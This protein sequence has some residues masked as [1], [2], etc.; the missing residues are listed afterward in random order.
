MRF[1]RRAEQIAM[2]TVIGG[3]AGRLFKTRE[4]VNRVERHLDVDRRGE[5]GAHAAHA[6][7]GR[8]ESLLLFAFD[9]QNVR[10]ARFGKVICDARS[11]DSSPDDDTVCWFYPCALH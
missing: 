1:G 6:L 11:D 2:R 8:T 3:V 10:A 9:D 7:A 4:E 5:L